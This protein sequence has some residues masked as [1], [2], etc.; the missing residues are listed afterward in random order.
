[1]TADFVFTNGK[2]AQTLTELVA[3]IEESDKAVFEQHVT[4]ER[5]DFAAWIEF[6]LH[7]KALAEQLRKTTDRTATISTLR[8]ALKPKAPNPLDAGHQKEFL[9]G[10]AIGII[11]GIILLRIVQVLA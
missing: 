1:M 4:K 10:L 7:E 9:F 3:V 5:N 8:G 2:K 6:G 11:L